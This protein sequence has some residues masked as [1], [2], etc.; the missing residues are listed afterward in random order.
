MGVLTHGNVRVSL[1][2][3]STEADVR[4]FLDA[5]PGVVAEVRAR[6]GADAL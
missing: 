2:P 1:H 5:L 4:R 6:L 3:G